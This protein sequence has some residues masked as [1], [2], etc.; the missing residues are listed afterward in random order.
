MGRSPSPYEEYYYTQDRPD[1]LQQNIVAPGQYDGN[2]VYTF[3][4]RQGTPFQG[5]ITPVDQRQPL[6][7]SAPSQP[8]T[9]PNAQQQSVIDYFRTQRPGGQQNQQRTQQQI[10]AEA[11]RNIRF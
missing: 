6:R 7:G 3:D 4:Q 1:Q 8:V 2:T 11:L 9:P 5:A 10:I